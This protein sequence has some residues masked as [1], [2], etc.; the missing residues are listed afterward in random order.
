MI[1]MR[2]YL[3]T[4]DISQIVDT[5][6]N[7]RFAMRIIVMSGFTHLPSGMHDASESI[8][9]RRGYALKTTNMRGREVLLKPAKKASLVVHHRTSEEHPPMISNSHAMNQENETAGIQPAGI[10]PAGTQAQH[11]GFNVVNPEDA[12]R[13]LL[14]AEP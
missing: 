5:V 9:V 2:V 1:L 12:G 4:L 8:R 11:A 13:W 7:A 3:C 6:R 10:Q 14:M